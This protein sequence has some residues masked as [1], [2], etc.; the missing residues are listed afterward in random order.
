MAS[1]Q[2]NALESWRNFFGTCLL[3]NLNL[4]EFKV[5]LKKQ[6]LLHPLRSSHIIEAWA[7]NHDRGFAVRSRYLQHFESLLH[8]RVITDEDALV[9]VLRHFNATIASENESHIVPSTIDQSLKSTIEAAILERMAY[10]MVNFRLATVSDGDKAP[11]IRMFRPLIMLVSAFTDTLASSASLN[12]AAL[13]IA[14]ELGKLV[15]A[16]INDLSLL[17]LLTCDGGA[18]PQG[19]FS[20]S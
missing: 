7:A 8:C 20:A 5:S 4:K 1:Q 15:A 9:Y 12:R 6:L 14:N 18:P 19:S 3:Y 11:S 16:Y 17:G 13:E 10:Q 2:S